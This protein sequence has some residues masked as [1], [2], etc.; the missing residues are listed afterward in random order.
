[1]NTKTGGDIF[2]KNNQNLQ[3]FFPLRGVKGEFKNRAKSPVRSEINDMQTLSLCAAESFEEVMELYMPMVYRIALSRLGDRSD[4][5]DV[6]Q[7]VFLRYFRTGMTYNSEEHR[8]AWLIRC[9]VNCAINT[10]S[11]AWNRH[12]ASGEALE[13]SADPDEEPAD[14]GCETQFEKT[15]RRL[16][17]LNLS[18]IHI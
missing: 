15:E 5:E 11:S 6:T 13:N 8:K 1:M 3:P 12:K 18:L 14:S 7:D 9:T 2:R 10:A 16:T 17:V 4:A